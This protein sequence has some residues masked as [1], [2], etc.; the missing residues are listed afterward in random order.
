MTYLIR[1]V[2]VSLSLFIVGNSFAASL[3]PSPPKI[4][5]KGYIL[6][7]FNSN[8]VLAEHKADQRMEP[9]SITKMMTVY[10]ISDALK[11]GTIAMQDM[12]RIS[13]KAWKMQGSR[14][15]VEV[16][17]EVSVKELLKG[18]I[19]QSGNDATVALAEHLA[20]TEEGFV[21]LMNEHARMLGMD[22]THFV[23]STG[24]PHKNHYST[25]RD[26]ALMARAL[27]KGYP[28]HYSWYSLKEYTY[29]NIKQYNRN[30][31]LWRNKFVDGVKTGHTESAGYCLV[32]S[33]LRDDMR[34]I[35]VV[36]GTKSENARAEESQKLLTY[37]FRFF[38]THRLYAAA[39]P[40]TE[41]RVWKGQMEQVP[42]GIEESLYITIPRGQY[43][44]LKASMK[45]ESKILAPV[46]KGQTYGMV[47]VMLGQESVAERSLVAL[48]DIEKGSL[49]QSLRDEFQLLI[50]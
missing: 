16:G 30:K 23:N 42:L 29:N 31:L 1:I 17:S 24:M 20:G 5:A 43:K 22:S 13:T 44:K 21:A 40:L 37:G 47:N 35:S 36:L 38:E 3:I 9:A 45:V 2:L 19:V 10:V 46:H 18:V 32:A 11:S 39:E 26:L 28:E 33:A 34:L 50:Q 12:V 4:K 41:M 25:P 48:S 27:I 49:W 6:L 8:R 14:M 7:D 15:F